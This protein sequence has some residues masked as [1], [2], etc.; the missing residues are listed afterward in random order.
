[1]RRVNYDA[2]QYLLSFIG[3]LHEFVA[4]D[5]CMTLL[6]GFVARK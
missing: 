3:Y 6:N 2:L 1:M 5:D 4:W